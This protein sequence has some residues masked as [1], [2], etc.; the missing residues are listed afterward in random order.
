M[1]ASVDFLLRQSFLPSRRAEP[2]ERDRQRVN[3]VKNEADSGRIDK[4]SP[5]SRSSTPQC[6]RSIPLPADSRIQTDKNME[7]ARCRFNRLKN[8][9]RFQFDSAT[10]LLLPIFGVFPVKKCIEKSI[11]FSNELDGKLVGFL[12]RLLNWPPADQRRRL[13]RLR[14]RRLGVA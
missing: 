10:C 9:L 12:K 5:P 14:V 3:E 2:N 4:F 7:E 13:Q 8:P 11:E 1:G 6:T